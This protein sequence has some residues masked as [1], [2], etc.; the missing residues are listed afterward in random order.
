MRVEL[1]IEVENA[2]TG[3]RT[4]YTYCVEATEKW[5]AE[6]I[7]AHSASMLRILDLQASATEDEDDDPKEDWKPSVAE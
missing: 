3:Y 4:V 2:E 1:S 7:E 5:S 6:T